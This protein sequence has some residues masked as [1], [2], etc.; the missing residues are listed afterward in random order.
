MLMIFSSALTSA[1]FVLVVVLVR[2]DSWDQF[3]TFFKSFRSLGLEVVL[4]TE[5]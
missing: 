1:T 2:F 4:G 5:V 3:F